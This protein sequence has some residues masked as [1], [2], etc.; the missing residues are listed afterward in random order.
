M[1]GE[2]VTS[3]PPSE[4]GTGFR[5]RWCF[6]RRRSCP[7]ARV[8][9]VVLQW[10]SQGAN[11]EGW[12]G[13]ERDFLVSFLPP[14]VSE[15]LKGGIMAQGKKWVYRNPDDVCR[16]EDKRICVWGVVRMLQSQ[17]DLLRLDL[18]RGSILLSNWSSIVWSRAPVDGWP[19]D[20]CSCR[21]RDWRLVVSAPYLFSYRL[22][23]TW[24]FKILYIVLF[25]KCFYFTSTIYAWV[26]KVMKTPSFSNTKR[27]GRTSH[28]DFPF[29][30]REPSWLTTKR[31][32][33]GT[34]RGLSVSDLATSNTT[35]DLSW[36][37]DLSR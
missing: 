13:S 27:D 20:A 22:W 15:V 29:S 37:L 32:L 11:R 16:V 1:S 18:F 34:G 3:T 7:E 26:H 8:R 30:D 28:F 5:L 35:P 25:Q 2:G 10:S 21:T 14:R 31:Y 33:L 6:L 12:W 19:V 24:R 17:S 9:C 4:S 36:P 23:R